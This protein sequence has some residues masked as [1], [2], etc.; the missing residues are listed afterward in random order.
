MSRMHLAPRWVTVASLGP[1]LPNVDSKSFS[2]HGF[3][4]AP[5][6]LDPSGMMSVSPYQVSHLEVFSEGEGNLE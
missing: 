2:S 3:R 4:M 6:S 5:R 1:P